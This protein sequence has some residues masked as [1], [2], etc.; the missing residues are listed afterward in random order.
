MNSHR[1]EE[2]VGPKPA[3][4]ENEQRLETDSNWQDVRHRR[5]AAFVRRQ[6][7]FEGKVARG[8]TRD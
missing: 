2:V 6:S 4:A 7:R 3:E 8:E 5:L 1:V